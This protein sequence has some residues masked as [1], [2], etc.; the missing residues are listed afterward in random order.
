MPRWRGA[1]T[2]NKTVD[3][4]QQGKW[5]S[6]G[7][8]LFP[9]RQL[10]DT[11]EHNTRQRAHIQALRDMISH[12]GNT[13]PISASVPASPHASFSRNLPLS[14]RTPAGPTASLDAAHT[15]PQLRAP[16][17]SAP[18]PRAV[19]MDV[20]HTLGVLLDSATFE[21]VRSARKRCKER[22]RE[23]ERERIRA[24]ARVVCVFYSLC[25]HDRFPV[26]LDRLTPSA[27]DHRKCCAPGADTAA[28][29]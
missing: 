16:R 26:C 8:R 9:M 20:S 28:C 15:A 1:S 29:V 23:R 10:M 18:L 22:E 2:R 4:L 14:P 7:K 11:Q 17:S 21:R 3:H 27:G 12:I 6:H 5:E 13:Q 19:S 24:C 25:T